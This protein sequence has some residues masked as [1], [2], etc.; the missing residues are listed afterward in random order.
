MHRF[1]KV[2]NWINKRRVR[3]NGRRTEIQF[4]EQKYHNQT[5][6]L[7]GYAYA[8]IAVS[9]GCELFS[10][11]LRVSFGIPS[12]RRRKFNTLTLKNCLIVEATTRK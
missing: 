4:D 8:G 1:V 12:K 2:G 6:G 5:D 3:Q 11:Y 9:S 7:F 10:K